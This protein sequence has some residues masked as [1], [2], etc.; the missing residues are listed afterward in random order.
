MIF[1]PVIHS[2]VWFGQDSLENNTNA[3][4][5]RFG[6]PEKF[7][8]SLTHRNFHKKLYDYQTNVIGSIRITPI[9]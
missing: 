3:I 2:P 6:H 9:P 5:I 4:P 1:D 8:N 7:Q